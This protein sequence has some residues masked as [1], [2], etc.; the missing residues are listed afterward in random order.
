MNADFQP[1]LLSSIAVLQ[2]V[3][4]HFQKS[5]PQN[6]SGSAGDAAKQFK[7]IQ[8]IA[9]TATLRLQPSALWKSRGLDVLLDIPLKRLPRKQQ[10][11]VSTRKRRP[12][13]I[14]QINHHGSPN[15]SSRR[16]FNRY[17]RKL[18]LR[19]SQ[20]RLVYRGGMQGAFV[21]AT[22]HIHDIGRRW[23]L[24]VGVSITG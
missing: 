10:H 9:L 7:V 6:Q 12:L 22:V 3:V 16:K 2:R 1:R 11:T 24:V 23:R 13:G 18:Q 8:R 20:K 21:R 4:L 5:K 15:S 14:P 19:P 17:S